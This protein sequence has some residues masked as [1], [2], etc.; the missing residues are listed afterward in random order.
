MEHGLVHQVPKH[1]QQHQQTTCTRCETYLNCV[2]TIRIFDR[3]HRSRRVFGALLCLRQ[4]PTALGFRVDLLYQV[5]KIHSMYSSQRLMAVKVVVV[6]EMGKTRQRKHIKLVFNSSSIQQ[7]INQEW[8]QLHH[9]ILPSTCFDSSSMVSIRTLMVEVGSNLC[10]LVDSSRRYS[11]LN[12]QFGL[13]PKNKKG[14]AK[15]KNE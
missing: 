12:F 6:V 10:S 5:Y 8:Q 2:K 3:E 4:I 13:V 7:C 14:R 1:Y 15:K 9:F 11:I